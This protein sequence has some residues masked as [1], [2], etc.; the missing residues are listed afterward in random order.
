MNQ[1]VL[2]MAV[3]LL[4][5]VMMV[6]PAFAKNFKVPEGVV[7][8]YFSS[9]QATVDCLYPEPFFLPQI[10]IYA[11][12]CEASIIGPGDNILISLFWI[13]TGEWVPPVNFCTNPAARD[14]SAAVWTG[15]PASINSILV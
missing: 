12:T 14:L 13:P 8:E 6:A 11:K 10:Q 1:K 3:A 5:A 2:S 7:I 15:L 4:F 9:G